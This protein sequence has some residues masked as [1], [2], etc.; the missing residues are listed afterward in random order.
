MT[1]R[2]TIVF[3]ASATTTSQWYTLDYRFDSLAERPFFVT[4]ASVSNQSMIIQVGAS[5]QDVN[6]SVAHVFNVSNFVDTSSSGV[7]LG[8][9]PSV[10]FIFS[11]NG[12]GKIVLVG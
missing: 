9:W 6:S 1:T 8:A 11:G 4:L 12:D 5:T 2:K 3:E 7:L 10:R